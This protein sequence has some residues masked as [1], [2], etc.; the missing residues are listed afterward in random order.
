M[1]EAGNKQDLA[2]LDDLLVP[3]YENQ[4][5]RLKSLEDLKQL[6]RIQ[7]RGFPDVHREILDIITEGDK[8]WARVKITGT[9]TSEYRGIAPTGKKFVMDAVPTYRII[10]GKIEEGWSV[11]DSL[12]MFK[13]LG[14]ID[15][16]GFPDESAENLAKNLSPDK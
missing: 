15:F 2:L 16:K 4:T 5:L 14:V 3:N 9:H 12:G 10:D 7:Y 8:V 11:W 13:I 6:L 1:L